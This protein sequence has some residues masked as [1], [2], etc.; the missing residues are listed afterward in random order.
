MK[1]DWAAIEEL[2]IEMAS[3]D[4]AGMPLSDGLRLAARRARRKG[5][6]SQLE[7]VARQ[8][9]AGV[10][11]SQAL[12]RQEGAFPG[13]FVSLVRAGEAGGNMLEALRGMTRFVERRRAVTDALRTAALYPLIVLA[14]ATGVSYFV[15]FRIF[16]DFI[17]RLDQMHLLAVH[18]SPGAANWFAVA[19]AAQHACFAVFALLLAVAV[20]MALLGLVAPSSRWYHR[21][22]LAMPVYGRVFR[23]Y[24]LYHFSGVASLL[25][26][27][28]VPMAVAMDNL[29]AL[30]DSPLLREAAVAARRAAEL[31]KPVSTGLESVDWFPRSELWLMANA[32]KQER[33]DD[34]LQDLCARTA[35]SVE[36]AEAV[37]RHLEPSL[38][39]CLAGS[40]PSTSSPCFFRSRPSSSMSGW[41]SR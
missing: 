41:G 3:L 4:A 11:L 5:F 17:G 7:D 34:Y 25:L 31:G 36:R 29:E 18:Q 38:I 30:D 14:I 13:I 2:S 28:G 35:R 37:F 32:E 10:P 39:M 22:L 21:L 16:P 40:L 33:L 19:I 27:G 12:A 9:E 24:L 1:H 23:N 20:A 26:G 6:V 8:C 15:T